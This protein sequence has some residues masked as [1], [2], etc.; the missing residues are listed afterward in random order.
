M[1]IIIAGVGII[2]RQITKVL[3]ENKHDVV[4]IDKNSDVCE[5]VYAETGALTIHGNAADIHVLEKA[6]AIKADVL[7]CLMREAADNI[8]CALLAKSLG[9][10]RIVMRLRNPRYEEAYRFAGATSV[11]RMADLIV[12]QMMTEIEQPK[13][14]KV[15]TLGGGKAGIYAAKIPEHA[16]CAGM[17]IK[18]IAGK[19]KFPKE[20]LVVGIY[21]EEKGDFLIPRGSHII[22]E[23]DI[24][25]IVSRSQFIK[26]AT[27]FFSKTR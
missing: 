21:K 23:K 8:A 15:M 3:V 25:F 22:E 17:S 24:V 2:G 10:P 4:A 13:V 20:C 12:N 14:K 7:V 9:I 18:E 16:R 26:K 6:G 1:Y 19:R 5:S 27:D 11:I